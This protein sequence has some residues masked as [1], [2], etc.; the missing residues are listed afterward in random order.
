MK[1]TTAISVKIFCLLFTLIIIIGVFTAC[2]KNDNSPDSGTQTD[3]T[4]TGSATEETKEPEDKNIYIVK[5][6]KP[7]YALVRRETFYTSYIQKVNTLFNRIFDLGGVKLDFSDDWIDPRKEFDP[8]APEIL[9]GLTNRDENLAIMDEVPIDG[10]VIRHINNKIIIAAHKE[11]NLYEAIDYFNENL[12]ETTDGKNGKNIIYKGDYTK[13]TMDTKYLFDKDNK[14]NDYVIVYPTDERYKNYLSYANSLAKAIKKATGVT[15][16]CVPDTTPETEKE[17]VLGVSSRKNDLSYVLEID[18]MSIAKYLVKNEGKKLYIAFKSDILISSAIGAFC[19]TYSSPEFSDRF[20]IPKDINEQNIGFYGDV[21]RTDRS[22]L[23]IMSYNILAELWDQKIPVETR[24]AKVAATILSYA[25]DVIG[26]QEVTAKWYTKLVGAINSDYKFVYATNTR[27]ETNYSSIAY[28]YHKIKLIDKGMEYFEG[29][30]SSHLRVA[31]W[32][33]FER[34]SDGK[35]FI[36]VNTHWDLT[37]EQR[38]SDAR[39]QAAV[40]KKVLEKYNVPVFSTGDFNSNENSA[41]FNEYL[42]LTDFADSIAVA[43]TVSAGTKGFH[44]VGSA[45]DGSQSQIIDHITISK[46]VKVLHYR[47]VKDTIALESSDHCPVI[48]DVILN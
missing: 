32:G 46:S 41:E 28:N 24:D 9:V 37:P 48:I 6:G 20:Y 19:N 43:E 14:L 40:M 18:K 42:N 11:S 10:Y 44:A 7:V 5:D 35:R 8:N 23:R 26:I 1:K 29:G 13:G 21:A 17:I 38:L 25:P 30:N 45:P 31:C 33:L 39:Q 22:D 47:T 27:G 15:L 4:P 36:V 2:K 3:N 34:I 12:L 16:E